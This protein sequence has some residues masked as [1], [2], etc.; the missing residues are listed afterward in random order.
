M[1]SYGVLARGCRPGEGILARLGGCIASFA[2]LHFN[3]NLWMQ[4]SAR[5]PVASSKAAV[6]SA[7]S[8]HVRSTKYAEYVVTCTGSHA[9]PQ[10]TH[11][12]LSQR[13]RIVVTPSIILN[14]NF[15]YSYCRPEN[16]GVLPCVSSLPGSICEGPASQDLIS[17]DEGKP[18]K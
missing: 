2:H 1:V 4:S 10:S 12:M 11:T 3:Y 13:S 6:G 18:S 7:R 15:A 5:R 17:K 8:T 14:Y 16:Q 9:R